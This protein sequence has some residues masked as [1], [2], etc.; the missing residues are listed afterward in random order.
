MTIFSLFSNV[1]TNDSASYTF[2]TSHNC[3]ISLGTLENPYNGCY[4]MNQSEMNA[5]YAKTSL[6]GK[7]TA[8]GVGYQKFVIPTTATYKL[9]CYGADGGYTGP[10]NPGN[11]SSYYGGRGA[12]ISGIYKFK[13]GQILYILIGHHGHCNTNTDGG[14]GGGGASAIFLVDPNGG[15]TFTATNE[16]VTPIIISGGGAGRAD[17]SYNTNSTDDIRVDSC[18]LNAK[19]TNGE[20]T[21]A[22]SSS[23]ASGG[24]S[25]TANSSS[26]YGLLNNAVSR[27][28]Y[29]TNAY[30]A[31]S[32]GFG[33]GGGSY[34]GGGGGGGFSGGSATNSR[35]SYGGTSWVDNNV[36][37]VIRG[38]RPFVA[39][40][41]PQDG[42]IEIKRNNKTIKPLKPCER[43]L[44][45]IIGEITT[46]PSG[47]L[48][49]RHKSNKGVAI[50]YNYQ[51]TDRVIVVPY[52][53]YRSTISTKKWMNANSVV[54]GLYQ[55]N[56]WTSI[57]NR[58]TNYLYSNLLVNSVPMYVE[59]S[60]SSRSVYS[61]AK[62]GTVTD[63]QL[64]TLML[65]AYQHENKTAKECGDICIAQNGLAYFPALQACRGFKE[66]FDDGM[67]QPLIHD[68]FML[69]IE[70]DNIDSL[71]PTVSSYTNWRLGRGSSY[72][73]YFGGNGVCWSCQQYNASQA[74]CMHYYGYVSYANKTSAYPVLPI[75][76]IFD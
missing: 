5:L 64:N 28:T 34:D 48:I 36:K 54:N 67:D 20:N 6:S 42:L 10:A 33:G 75:K 43:F 39:N 47:R 26:G 31:G 3:R 27:T 29:F 52:A 11:T 66:I 2:K 56:S 65:P 22:G 38:L 76:E 21:S 46:T 9:T 68:I 23:N 35:P 69:Y 50:Q 40:Q 12:C 1:A 70:G 58:N 17:N 41:V 30:G 15:Y 49:A 63:E 73:W 19:W 16:K 55:F 32:G 57:F 25:I 8:I 51:N 24:G 62:L 13:K 4:G 61:D 71:D 72:R 37:S 18:A 53:Q 44:R 45:E 59:S 14:G 60:T 7:V 74:I